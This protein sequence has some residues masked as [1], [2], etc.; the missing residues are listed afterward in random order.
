M[1]SKIKVGNAILCE[2][3]VAGLGNKH[4]LINVFSGDVVVETLP[5]ALRLA[6]YIEYNILTDDAFNI[7][8]DVKIDK[9]TPMKWRAEIQSN[10]RNQMGILA[11]PGFEVRL[12]RNVTLEVRMTPDGERANTVLKKNI[13][14]GSVT[15][16]APSASPPPS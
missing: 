9:Y 8:V 1:P 12:D 5:A 2:Y 13:Y 15:T 10:H 14:L 16:G 11:V 3:L 4:T 7:M 6:L